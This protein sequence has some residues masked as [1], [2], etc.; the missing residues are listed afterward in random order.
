ML[1][2]LGVLCL[3]AAL[4]IGGN[5]A[6]QLWG[7]GL[8]TSREQ[9]QLRDRFEAKIG[10]R[11][12]AQAPPEGVKVP[13]SAV[14][15]LDIPRMDLDMVLVEGTDTEPLKKGPGHYTQTAYPWEDTGRVGIAGH[16]T[17]YGAPFWDLDKLRPGDPIILK[18]EYGIFRYE[19]TRSVITDPTGILP[20][21]RSVLDQTRRP[22]LVLTTCEPRFS[23]ARRLIV[24]ADRV[25]AP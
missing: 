6:W 20:T 22:T 1:R 5:L 19:V 23:A 2:T 8:T 21:G 24:F 25:P 3:L 18:T 15:I 9:A 10:T 11:A 16:R 7:T 14:A 12:P 13:G 4:A 17:T